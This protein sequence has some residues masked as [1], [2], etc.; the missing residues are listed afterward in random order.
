MT[1]LT[2]PQNALHERLGLLRLAPIWLLASACHLVVSPGGDVEDT[3][4]DEAGVEARECGDR[5]CGEDTVCCN[6]SCG[7]C[8]APGNVCIQIACEPSDHPAT[9]KSVLCGP[10]ETCM[11]TPAGAVCV[12]PAENPCNLVD[13]QPNSTCKV[14]Q[15]A[16]ICTPISGGSGDAGVPVK[17]DA[18]TGG[19]S[20]AGTPPA[21]DAGS[22]RDAAGP[23][24]DDASTP[25][26]DASTAQ[27]ASVPGK[28][29]SQPKDTGV[30]VPIT[31]AVVLCPTGTY[32]DDISG[33]AECIP[34]PSCNTVKCSAGYHCE[35]Q[36]VQCIRAPCPPH[37]TCV[38]DKEPT[39]CDTLKCKAG[40]HCELTLIQCI[41]T[42]C[43]PIAQCVPDKGGCGC[44]GKGACLDIICPVVDPTY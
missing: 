17:K 1:R 2:F 42:P 36:Q 23:A 6:A 39:T 41:T 18:G 14:E 19:A 11:E 38:A 7:I 3:D 4:S 26:L 37:P 24:P 13:C 15:G 20:D 33:V 12:P 29:A 43:D 31:C 40:T 10:S 35:L 34:L 44:S 32:C 22:A 16:P 27:D 9:C 30:V 8:T 21:L 28:D 5:T 25:S